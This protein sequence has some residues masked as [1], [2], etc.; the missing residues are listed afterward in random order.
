MSKVRLYDILYNFPV[1]IIITDNITRCDCIMLSRTCIDIYIIMNSYGFLETIEYKN[2]KRSINLIK[3]HMRTLKYINFYK[4]KDI[5]TKIPML[6]N[7]IQIRLRDCRELVANKD[8]KINNSVYSMILLGEKHNLSVKEL[9]KFV[10]L[11][12]VGI[13]YIKQDEVIKLKELKIL[14]IYGNININLFDCKKLTSLFYYISKDNEI[15]IINLIHF[16]KLEYITIFLSFYTKLKKIKIKNTIKNIKIIVNTTVYE[17][18][19]ENLNIINR[20]FQNIKNITLID[21]YYLIK[22][23][24]SMFDNLYYY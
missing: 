16:K 20:N 11:E 3:S 12:T 7:K 15:D 21:D 4:K 13:E 9:N 8:Q 2:S 23:V 5:F 1:Y 19:F 17:K 14:K 22:P 10:N 24:I 18:N 6:N